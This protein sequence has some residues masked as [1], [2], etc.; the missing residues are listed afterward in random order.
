MSTARISSVR[1]RRSS[2]SQRLDQLAALV[3]LLNVSLVLFDLSYI[4]LR[5]L[6][7]HYLPQVTRYDIVKGI[8]PHR[9]T[10]QYLAAVDNLARLG[11]QNPAAEQQLSDLRDRSVAMV[12]EDPFRIAN[13]SGSL[14]KLKN[15]MRQHM[16]QESSR[17]AFQRFWSTQHLNSQNWST[18]LAYF[19]RNFRPILA[20]N[21]YRP[22]DESGNF[23]DLFW[24]IDLWFT[25][26]FVLDISARVLWI[27]QQRRESLQEAL[28]WRWYDLLLLLPFWRILR[29]IPLTIRL[30]EAG[31]VDLQAVQKQVNRNLAEN[32]VGEVTEL[33]LLQTFRMVQGGI[34][35]GA[36]RQFLELSPGDIRDHGGNG[37]DEIAVLVRR[38][39]EIVTQTVLPN[40]QPELEQ[41][42][43]HVV[44]QAISQTPLTRSL[45][46]LP[47][48]S[49]LSTTLSKQ[50]A[51]Q[52]IQALQSI[53]SEAAN[54]IEGQQLIQ[55][56]GQSSL[57]HF[58][59]GLNQKHTLDEIEL[60]LSTWI[61]ELKLTTV[62]RLESQDHDQTLREVESIRQLR[63][64][65]QVLPPLA[66]PR[67]QKAR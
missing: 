58:Q 22:I 13:K 55:Q 41:V 56:L 43:H 60:L 42:I 64:Q 1:L 66:N 44:E 4:R 23:V 21:Y 53:L 50:I 26:F 46:H 3:V 32:I 7:L 24:K 16:H 45:L 38:L 34:Q 33:V 17:A 18:E 63:I 27:R 36:L 54:D 62:E 10:A 40:I 48:L 51:H 12:M 19:N 49:Q 14:E 37:V 15:R 61:E 28:L 65:P 59:A 30:H 9:D 35:Q 25:G 20:A 2:W 11:I 6:Y 8:E 31:L 29:L 47:G 5:D 52:C 67:S 57:T 39:S